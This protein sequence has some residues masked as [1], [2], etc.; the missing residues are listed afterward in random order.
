M[1]QYFTGFFT[2][3]CLMVSAVMFMGAS[4]YKYS[5][6]RF[7]AFPVGSNILDHR[8]DTLYSLQLKDY[9]KPEYVHL[10]EEYYFQKLAVLEP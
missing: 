10:L 2:G 6:D 8:T 7:E 3:V 4:N 9:L 5:K 1:K